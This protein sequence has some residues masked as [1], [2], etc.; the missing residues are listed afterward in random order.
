MQANHLCMFLPVFLSML[1]HPSTLK[2]MS[3]PSHPIF[4]MW[5]RMEYLNACFSRQFICEADQHTSHSLS[6]RSPEQGG[7]A[8]PQMPSFI[9]SPT[10]VQETIT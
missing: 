9:I 5:V 6:I 2:S 7:H 1:F 10:T 3:F 4:D 8:M